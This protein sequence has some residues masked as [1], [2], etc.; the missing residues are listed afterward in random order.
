[1]KNLLL[2]LVLGVF[3]LST[4]TVSAQKEDKKTKKEWKKKAKAYTKDPLSLKSF[5][6]GYRKKLFDAEKKAKEL[7]DQ[8]SRLT[9]KVDSLLNELKKKD[10]EIAMLKSDL[11]K[12][13]AEYSKLEAA[14]SSAKA[15]SEKGVI[16]GLVFKVQIGAFIHFN[17]NDYLKETV[18][19]EGES[20][21]NYNKYV[22]GAFRDLE[23]AEAFKKDIARMGIKD[24]WVV[25]YVDG[26]RVE[27]AE[28]K[29]ILAG[30]GSTSSFKKKQ[31]AEFEE[32]SAPRKRK[33]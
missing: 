32:E 2:F 26:V 5:E 15:N 21:D 24:A 4:G 10:A 31:A 9:I 1:M 3:L 25:P 7:G 13:R 12:L 28:A 33:R 23:V 11:D 29:K 6:E 18:N 19:F 22:V 14:Y 8:N 27:M 16:A 17:M 30:G 20:A